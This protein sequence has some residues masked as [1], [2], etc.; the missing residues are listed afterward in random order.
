[1]RMLEFISGVSST[2][3]SACLLSDGSTAGFR[4]SSSP[5]HWLLPPRYPG[6]G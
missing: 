5:R 3:R 2:L 6:E 4:G 1:M